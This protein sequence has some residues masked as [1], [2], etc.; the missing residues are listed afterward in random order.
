M[1]NEIQ[2]NPCMKSVIAFFAFFKN[3]KTNFLQIDISKVTFWKTGKTYFQI[4]FLL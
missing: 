2:L 3:L 4:L 1:E